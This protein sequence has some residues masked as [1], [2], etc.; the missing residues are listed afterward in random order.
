MLAGNHLSHISC[1]SLNAGIFGALFYSVFLAC[2]FRGDFPALF[3]DLSSFYLSVLD[4]A[5]GVGSASTPVKVDEDR[6]AGAVLRAMSKPSLTLHED[7][8]I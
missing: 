3:A 6:F 2:W 5:I 8:K 4:A 1:S 7:R